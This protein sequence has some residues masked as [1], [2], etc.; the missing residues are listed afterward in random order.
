MF[1]ASAF[2]VGRRG[3]DGLVHIT[4][5][6]RPGTAAAGRAG[7]AVVL[8]TRVRAVLL[9]TLGHAVSWGDTTLKVR[10]LAGDTSVTQ[11]GR[12]ALPAPP[13]EYTWNV[14]L[15]VNDTVGGYA[16]HGRLRVPVFEE[17]RVRLSD[18]LLA[19]QGEG[20]AWAVPG[21]DT[22]FVTPR[23][24]WY[25]DET[26]T[27]YHEIYGLQEGE[28]YTSTLS[29]KRGKRTSM[30]ASSTGTGAASV[31]RVYRTLSLA[32]VSPGNYVLE[33]AVKGEK[34][35]WT[36]GSRDITVVKRR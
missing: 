20:A 36:R 29:L 30:S 14:A 27:L 23:A 24:R 15:S 2:A 5:R 33:I 9:D 1:E 32:D 31:T 10:V 25:P 26:L 3:P 16:P 4:W 6:F 19:A 7:T 35:P 13:G 8:P 17:G 34:G 22:A 11:V 12:V 21:G 18:L 28:R